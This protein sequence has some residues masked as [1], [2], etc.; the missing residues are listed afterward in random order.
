MTK[1][2]SRKLH[3]CLKV[4]KMGS[5]Y[6]R[7]AAPRGQRHIPSKNLLK[8]PHPRNNAL[9]TSVNEGLVNRHLPVI[10]GELSP[11]GI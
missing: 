1:L 8:D 11:D 4:T 7:V 2:G 9:L 10:F 6:K 3:I 5:D